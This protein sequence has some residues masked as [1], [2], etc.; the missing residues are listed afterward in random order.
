MQVLQ[1]NFAK[2]TNELAL[3]ALI[4]ALS[5]HQGMLLENDTPADHKTIKL[6]LSGLTDKRAKVKCVWAT[7]ISRIIWDANSTTFALITFSKNIAKQLFGVFSEI[8]QNVVQASQNGTVTAGY[9]IC[10]AAIARWLEWSDTEL[11]N[12]SGCLSSDYS[13]TDESGR[14]IKDLDH[15]YPKAF[16]PPQ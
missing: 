6:V 10:A 13:A 16:F 12:S 9:A 2:E 8:T 7:A 15:R 11:S 5:A 14:G 1:P 4:D 3:S